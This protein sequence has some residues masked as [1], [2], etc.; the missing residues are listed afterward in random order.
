MQ[1][2]ILISKPP[3]NSFSLLILCPLNFKN[4]TSERFT[5]FKAGTKMHVNLQK[6]LD[7]GQ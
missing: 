1:T 5:S 6:D 3:D 7:S 2:L 4:D